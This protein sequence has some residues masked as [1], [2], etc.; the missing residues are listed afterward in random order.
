[1]KA[2]TQRDAV[3]V[4]RAVTYSTTIK[5][6]SD[7]IRH[8]LRLK[9]LA[10]DMDELPELV[11]AELSQGKIVALYSKHDDATTTTDTIA[12]HTTDDDVIDEQ[13]M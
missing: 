6:T 13:P 7:I 8:R 4:M 9:D 2:T 11:V 1:M 5:N 12:C 10:D 3:Q